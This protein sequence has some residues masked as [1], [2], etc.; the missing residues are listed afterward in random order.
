MRLIALAGNPNVGKSTLFNA[1]TGMRQ[2]TGNWSG[3]TVA[4]AQGRYEY[5]GESYRI[6]DLPGTYS[7]VSRS[8]EEK[9]AGTFLASGE[10]DCTVVVCDATCLERSLILAL[11]VMEV[12]EN[13]ILCINLIDEAERNG[14]VI[15][16]NLLER[17]LGVPV[18]M[19]SAGKRQGLQKLSEAVRSVCDGFSPMRPKRLGCG[20]ETDEA[21]HQFVLAAQEI[22]QRVTRQKKDDKRPDDILLHRR[23]GKVSMLVLLFLV[24]F[25]TV[26]GANYPSQ[27]L[28]SCFDKLGGLLH[29]IEMPDLVRSIFLDGVYATTARVIAVMLPPMAI[30]F[31][32]F[33][34]LEDL[35]YLPRM[36]FL[37]DGKFSAAGAC[38]KQALTMCMGFG[39]NA[40]G[41]SGCRII[42]SP[43]ERKIALL[44][45][46]FV[47]CNGRFSILIVLIGLSFSFGSSV[48][49][50]GMLTA[51]IVLSIAMTLLASR[52]LSRT[53]LS[54]E[55]SSFVLELPPY[56]RPRIMQVLVRS[57]IDRV[58]SILLRAII[59]AA[60]AGA[61]LQLLANVQL[62]GKPLLSA[63]AE[64]FEPVGSLLGMS[65]AVIL[66]FILG[67]PANE[68][69]LPILLMLMTGQTT[70][71]QLSAE[72]TLAYNGWT[73]QM[74]LCT[75][76]FTLFHWP[77][78]TTLVTIYKESRSLKQTLA[79][80]V[81]PTAFGIALCFAVNLFI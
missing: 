52:L 39:C 58:A 18:V 27:I 19:T 76:I 9:I 62:G 63:L 61:I 48:L 70:F 14:I 7:L 20:I 59:V 2:H 6:V 78:L 31:P 79:A 54:G 36:A 57:C 45:N 21:A 55:A 25:L 73:W 35:G 67:S 3:K 60:P 33:T 8:P 12:C 11:Q 1:L 71:T 51:C 29:S 17:Q 44:T 5:K 10:A 80:A 49:A 50:A 66:A 69:V 15:D 75:M 23:Y 40:V 65:G 28:Q 72:Q 24:L 81:L 43:R 56:R 22:A 37:L 30:F 41:V 47:P 53:I 4:L 77:C 13:V 64:G 74:S 32:L 68:L 46:A 34:I 42:D 16:V 38:G 26:E